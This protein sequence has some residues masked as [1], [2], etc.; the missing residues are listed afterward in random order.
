MPTTV[1][2]IIWAYGVVLV[3]GL[4]LALRRL[5]LPNYFELEGLPLAIAI[6]SALTRATPTPP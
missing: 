2:R 3:G 6:P 5:A 4:L 1:Q